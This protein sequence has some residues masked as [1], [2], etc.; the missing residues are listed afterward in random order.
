[1]REDCGFAVPL[2]RFSTPARA[3]HLACVGFLGREVTK[4]RAKL[5]LANIRKKPLGRQVGADLSRG[6]AMP[7]QIP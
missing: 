6:H 4:G 7:F 5:S 2:L 3:N 1:M